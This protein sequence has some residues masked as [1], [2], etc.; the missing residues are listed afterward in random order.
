MILSIIYFILILGLIVLVHEFGHFIFAKIFHV[1]VYEFAIGMGPKVWSSEKLRAKRKKAGKKVSETIYSI[2]LIPIGGFNQLAGEG[3]EEDKKVPKKNLLGSKPAWQR[4]LI[5]FFGAGN[6]FILAFVV[7][8]LCAFI[9]GSPD[10]STTVYEVIPESPFADAGILKGDK[11]LSINN[12]NVKTLDDVQIYM[13]IAGENETT[14]K[15]LRNNKEYTYKVTPLTGEEKEEKGYSFGIKF[16]NKFERGF[17]RSF[18]YA[19]HKFYSITRQVFITIKELFTG[20]VSVKQLSGPVG[21]FTIV[22]SQAEQGLEAVLYLVAYLSIN[23]GVMNLIPFPAFDGGH[24]LFLII[25]KIRRKPLSPNVEATITGIGFICL[26]LLMIYV[27]CHD[28]L[29]LIS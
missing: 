23:V 14:F 20:G 3:L 2:R 13:A 10:T 15:I 4:F 27:T 21:I 8:L 11:I 16:N 18:K 6:N 28:V 12:K 5:M 7:L 1:H 22:D 17:I 26:I 29:N 19:G 9:F 24:I 25:E